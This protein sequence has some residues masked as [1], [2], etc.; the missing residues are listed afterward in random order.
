MMSVEI[1]PSATTATAAAATAISEKRSISLELIRKRTQ[2]HEGLLAD[3]RDLDL[4]QDHLHE[5]GPVLN[6]TCPNIRRLYLHNNLLRQ[7][8]P[9]DVCRLSE[10]RVL[11]LALNHL[12]SIPCLEHQRAL[13]YLDLSF[14]LIGLNR[15]QASLDGLKD[16]TNLSDLYVTA[17]P[18]EREWEGYRMFVIASL[19][20]LKRL[21]GIV[22]QDSERKLAAEQWDHWIMNLVEMTEHYCPDLSVYDRHQTEREA[23]SDQWIAMQEKIDQD[24]RQ[25]VVSVAPLRKHVDVVQ[26]TRRQ[27]L[28][29]E[30]RNVNEGNFLFNLDYKPDH[31]VLSIGISKDIPTDDIDLDVKADYVSLVIQAQVLRVRL[32]H[33]IR[34]D[35]TQSQRSQATGTLMLILPTVHDIIFLDTD[36]DAI[37]MNGES[38][39][40]KTT[41]STIPTS[42]EMMKDAVVIPM[43]WEGLDQLALN[44]TQDSDAESSDEEDPPEMY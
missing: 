38:V 12:S 30:R 23:M 9:I 18:C 17:N 11:V 13:E 39:Q 29:G 8:A 42:R 2:D 32:P 33:S 40:P 15:F 35:E 41:S 26:S 1:Q 36:E 31:L 22:I 21:D 28:Q 4:H 19:P 7:W 6:R 16:L 10:L 25:S 34:H 44:D 43:P 37:P 5:I 24:R 20:Q 14:N 27:E 3:L